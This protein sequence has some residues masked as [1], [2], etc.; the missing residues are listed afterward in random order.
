MKKANSI[1]KL[2]RLLT[3]WLVFREKTGLWKKLRRRKKEELHA[4]SFATVE[5]KAS[6]SS[7]PRSPETNG[8]TQAIKHN[9]NKYYDYAPSATAEAS[10]KKSPMQKWRKIDK[11]EKTW[12]PFFATKKMVHYSLDF[13]F[14]WIRE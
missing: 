8:R 4:F 11:I 13:A 7:S 3:A 14:N 12:L 2:N 6:K 5:V 1:P 9:Y 10:P